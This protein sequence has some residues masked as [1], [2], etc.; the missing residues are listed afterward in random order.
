M[1]KF[2]PRTATLIDAE[3]GFI[4][5]VTINSI[6]DIQSF[7]G[8][9]FDCVQM[10]DSETLYIN[11]EGLINGTKFGFTINGRQFAGNGIILGYLPKSGRSR[12]TKL[13]PVTLTAQY[14][15]GFYRLAEESA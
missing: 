11:D 13:R 8:G 5:E 7:V 2:T 9:Y 14:R 6:E 10:D 12:S 1:P 15:I 3:H 4:R